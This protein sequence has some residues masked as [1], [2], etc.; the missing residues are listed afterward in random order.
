MIN[1]HLMWSR[2]FIYMAGYI[3]CLWAFYYK[4]FILFLYFYI[5]RKK[6]KNKEKSDE[7]FREFTA[8]LPPGLTE[9]SPKKEKKFCV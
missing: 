8:Q 6:I 5:I 9:N 3:K 2:A 4:P 7:Y 1:S